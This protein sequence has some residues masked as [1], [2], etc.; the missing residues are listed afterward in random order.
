MAYFNYG[1][2]LLVKSSIFRPCAAYSGVVKWES[3]SGVVSTAP[4][5]QITLHFYITPINL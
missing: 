1:F 3:F 5:D 4:P 2:L